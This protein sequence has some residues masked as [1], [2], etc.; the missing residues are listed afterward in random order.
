MIFLKIVALILCVLNFINAFQA[1]NNSAFFGWLTSACW[2]LVSLL[3]DF[4]D[5]DD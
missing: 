5:L 4:S 1:D 3:G 2:V